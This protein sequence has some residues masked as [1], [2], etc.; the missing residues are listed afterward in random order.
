MHKLAKQFDYSSALN[1]PEVPNGM[2]DSSMVRAV[3]QV[4]ECN[5]VGQRSRVIGQEVTSY[6]CQCWDSYQTS[7]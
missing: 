4:K 1:A 2:P 6:M 3:L 5:S 7:Y